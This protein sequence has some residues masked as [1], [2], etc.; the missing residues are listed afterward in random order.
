MPVICSCSALFYL[1]QNSLKEHLESFPRTLACLQL[2]IF[3]QRCMFHSPSVVGLFQLLGW[4]IENEE[5]L[6]GEDFSLEK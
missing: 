5:S 3:Y 4:W 6:K 2:I 1:N